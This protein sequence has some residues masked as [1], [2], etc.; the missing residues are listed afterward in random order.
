MA[1]LDERTV[2]K[3][4]QI[5]A[6][7]ITAR[8]TQVVAA[9]EMLDEGATVPFIARYRKERTG[10]LDDTQLRALEQRL[11]YLRDLEKRRAAILETI[12]KQGKLDAALKVKIEQAD[13]RPELED[14]Y[15]PFKVKA[16]DQ[17][18]NRHQ[19]WIGTVGAKAVAKSGAR[20]GAR[21]RDFFVPRT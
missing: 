12:D 20:S 13:S 5:L 16:P 17:G 10:G 3:I 18:T 11:S 4:A 2:R 1:G 19:G 9:I 8:E 6:R 15:L 14:L 21:S 7:E